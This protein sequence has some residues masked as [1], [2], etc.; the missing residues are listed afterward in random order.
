[1]IDIT[2]N[3]KDWKKLEK[4]L[5]NMRKTA[6]PYAVNAYLN[7]IAFETMGKGR[8]IA[9]SRMILRNKYTVQSIRANKATY[10]RD[11]NTMRSSAGS[12]AEYMEKQELG[13]TARGASGRN[14]PIATSDASGESGAST[15][16]RL[17]TAANSQ[18]IL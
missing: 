1:M 12:V 3:D 13:G 10:S 8:E 18:S 11:I 9:Q 4:D 5:A 14:K 2:F 15:R 16:K 7:A 17:P 6:L